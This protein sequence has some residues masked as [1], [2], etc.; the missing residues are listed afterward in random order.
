MK[1]AIH[2]PQYLP[3]LPYFQKIENVDLFV[4][5]DNVDFQKNGLQNRNEIMTQHGRQWLT[6]PISQKVN[7]KIREV[8]LIQ[9]NWQAKHCETIRHAY[10]KSDFFDNY[11]EDISAHYKEKWKYLLDLN[12]SLNKFLLSK[13][14]IYTPTIL[15]SELDVSG[16]SSDLVLNICMELGAKTY[17]TGVGAKNYLIEENFLDQGIEVMYHEANL[18]QRYDQPF[19]ESGFVRDL[20]VIDLL[21]NCGPEWRSYLASPKDLT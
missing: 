11:F 20:S 7:Q 12:L 1:I 17:I 14:N 6:V 4:Y 16:T 19:L 18:P 2:Q 3:W 21:F 13:L 9:N 5:L 8:E 10:G 15:A